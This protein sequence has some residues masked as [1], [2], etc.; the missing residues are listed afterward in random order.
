MVSLQFLLVLTFALA[1]H[2]DF[3][4]FGY[5]VSAIASAFDRNSTRQYDST[6]MANTYKRWQAIEEEES[7]LR[8]LERVGTIVG[9]TSLSRPPVKVS[10]VEQQLWDEDAQE[11]KQRVAKVGGGVTFH[12][13]ML[14]NMPDLEWRSL[15]ISG[16][17]FN[18]CQLLPWR[19]V[20]LNNEEEGT[21]FCEGGYCGKPTP[22][23][24]TML[25]QKRTLA[26]SDVDR[27]QAQGWGLRPK[28]D[29]DAAYEH[30]EATENFFAAFRLFLVKGTQ[31]VAVVYHTGADKCSLCH[32]NHYHVIISR[33]NKTLFD[34]DYNWRRV[35]AALAGAGVRGNLTANSQ[36]VGSIVA[37]VAYLSRSPRVWLGTN[38]ALLMGVRRY[39]L[40]QEAKAAEERQLA[41]Q[42]AEQE[43]RDRELA[44]QRAIRERAERPLEPPKKK[45]VNRPMTKEEL[46]RIE[47]LCVQC[48]GTTD[49]WDDDL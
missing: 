48:P 2:A 49:D 16:D 25:C 19:L 38:S 17:C 31:D 20:N 45:M 26:P 30:C 13:L 32:G 28:D 35:R 21:N 24:Y 7:G 41:T 34:A 4:R 18:S 9:V 23:T 27:L 29:V 40:E 33:N 43:K 44:S 39:H 6:T 5:L 1:A 8:R 42:R 15:V 22:H 3:A 11:Y 37:L 46:D 47:R 12:R 36:R 14:R 10:R